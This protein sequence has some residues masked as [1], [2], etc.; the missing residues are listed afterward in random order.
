[1]VIK[2]QLG[3]I[4]DSFLKRLV[5]SACDAGATGVFVDKPTIT[6]RRVVSGQD[7]IDRFG[8]AGHSEWITSTPMSALRALDLE[9]AFRRYLD[10]SGRTLGNLDATTAIDSMTM[11]YTHHRVTDVDL[12]SDG[13]MLLFQWGT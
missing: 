1:M 7:H 3:D 5:R 8:P 9:I 12:E 11:F 4:H 6:H 2:D 13:D 10:R